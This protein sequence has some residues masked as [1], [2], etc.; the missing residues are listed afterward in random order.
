MKK[1]KYQLNLAHI[2]HNEE[3][4]LA[5]RTRIIVENIK[6]RSWYLKF[7]ERE[8]EEMDQIL[9]EL[10]DAAD[11]NDTEWWDSVWSAFYDIADA[12]GVW[13]TTR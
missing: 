4:T 6:G 8:K 5:D 10:Q 7:E 11:E 1:W 13:V 12:E 3:R 2:F 9:E